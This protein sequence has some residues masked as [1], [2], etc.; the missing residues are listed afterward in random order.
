[1]LL[2]FKKI[3]Y[4]EFGSRSD[5]RMPHKYLQGIRRDL[6]LV[7]EKGI[8]YILPLKKGKK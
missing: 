5:L 4:N 6:F 1:M 3:Y 7:L 8:T 2:H